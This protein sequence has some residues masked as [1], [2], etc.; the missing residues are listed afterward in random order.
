M[1]RRAFTLIE[2]LA[3]IAIIGILVTLSVVSVQRGQQGARLRGAV[4][5]VFAT[6]R[7]ARSVALVTQK[8]CIITFSTQHGG[9]TAV[10][11]VEIT[12]AELLKSSSAT[13]ARTL[14]GRWI[15]IGDGGDD[16][17]EGHT[18]EE[19]L[20]QPISEEVLEGICVKVVMADEEIET[21]PGE[22]NE[23]KKSMISTFSN[24]DFLL[25]T[26]REERA[27]QKAAAAAEA[28]EKEREAAAAPAAA[29]AA[30]EGDSEKSL[31]WQVNG[32]CEP[33]TVYVYADGADWQRDA[34]RIRVDRF[35]AAKILDA[36]ED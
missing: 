5:D 35:G 31:A 11:K 34:W 33:H 3:I 23:A 9:D 25:G 8:P 27:K 18:V 36:E 29:P 10:S 6:I 26:Y 4:R 1:L 16:G 28:A 17:G 20:F 14:D 24:V 15:T 13:R 19:M 32:R 22:V 21:Y 30:A 7:Q 12:S 2:L